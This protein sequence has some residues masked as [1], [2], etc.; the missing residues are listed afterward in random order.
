MPIRA[1]GIVPVVG[2][3]ATVA[4]LLGLGFFCVCVR[5]HKWVESRDSGLLAPPLATVYADPEPEP[6]E[7][8]AI[9]SKFLRRGDFVESQPFA[10]PAEVLLKHGIGD[11]VLV[12][13]FAQPGSRGIELE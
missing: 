3:G 11:D 13:G 1:D 2:V 7:A 6:E 12:R 4:V 8:S 5:R 10:S 9:E